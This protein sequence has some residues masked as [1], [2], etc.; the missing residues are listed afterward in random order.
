ML[1]AVSR[2]KPAGSAGDT[3]QDVT[4]PPPNVVAPAVPIDVLIVNENGVPA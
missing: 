1:Q 4:A 2:L 3:E